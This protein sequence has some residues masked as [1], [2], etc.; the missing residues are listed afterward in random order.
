MCIGVPMRIVALD[1]IVAICEGRGGRERIDVALVPGPVVGDF[2]LAHQGRAVRA[3]TATEAA[4]TD[5]AL[6]AL[7]AALRGDSSLDAYFADLVGRE[8]ELPPHLRRPS[9]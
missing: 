4:Q 6:D 7:E 2:V 1:G 8:P 3:M 9:E 5:A